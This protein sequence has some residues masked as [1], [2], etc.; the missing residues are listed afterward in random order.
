MAQ[1][2]TS[3]CSEEFP[4]AVLVF[5]L[6][7]CLA[8][9]SPLLCLHLLSLLPFSLSGR[10]GKQKVPVDREKI[11]Y[12]RRGADFSP[13]A[14]SG[15]APGLSWGGICPAGKRR[16]GEYI[17]RVTPLAT[18]TLCIVTKCSLIQK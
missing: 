3:L 18:N 6:P 13:E 1:P 16:H 9:I 4:D 11:R 14:N 12:G 10:W 17:R 5:P 2:D 7:S 15:K 8:H